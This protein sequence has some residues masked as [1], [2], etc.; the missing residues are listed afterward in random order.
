[1]PRQDDMNSVFA[2]EL[3]T[4]K[5]KFE[6]VLEALNAIDKAINPALERLARE[7]PSFASIRKDYR[8]AIAKLRK[9]GLS[10]RVQGPAQTEC[11]SCHA[12]LRLEGNKGDRCDW[13]GY[14]F[15][16]RCPS[17]KKE[18]PNMEGNPGDTCLWC[19]HEF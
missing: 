7:D 3:T 4:L 8:T 12:R 10:E 5:G 11:P 16:L 14:I 17:C 13:C 6:V 2:T 18:L 15:P 1:M 9:E 19:R